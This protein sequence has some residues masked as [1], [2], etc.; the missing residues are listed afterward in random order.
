MI[1]V[2]VGTQLPFDRLIRAV[3]EWSARNNR[4][5]VF[6]QIGPQTA[7]RP[8]HIQ[9]SHF[10]AAPE[11]RRWVERADLII[12]HAGMGTIISALELGKPLIVMPRR[13]DLHEHRNDHQFAT[14]ERLGERANVKV[15]YEAS[16]LEQSLNEMATWKAS[17]P[18]TKT[19]SPQ[20]LHAIRRFINR[21]GVELPVGEQILA[22]E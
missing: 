4:N 19:A 6:A 16:A 21:P 17:K 15:A 12:S 8:R 11:C 1:F 7:Y 10:V 20:L 5:D 13:S 22:T 9:W 18:I 3:D 2:T 14:V